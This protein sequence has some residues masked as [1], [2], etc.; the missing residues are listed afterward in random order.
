MISSD[1]YRF[2]DTPVQSFIISPGERFDFIVTGDQT[3]G[4]Y[5]I[6]AQ[7]LEVGLTHTAEAI[8]SYTDNGEDVS[9]YYYN[10]PRIRMIC[11]K[12]ASP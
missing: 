9:I 2:N 11:K 12:T 7:T 3:A 10:I 8:L 1:G 4:C 5:Y 6:R